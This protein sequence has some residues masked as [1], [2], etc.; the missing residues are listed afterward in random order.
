MVPLYYLSLTCRFIPYRRAGFAKSRS[1]HARGCTAGQK[2]CGKSGLGQQAAGPLGLRGAGPWA[3]AG[4]SNRRA[5]GLVLAKP[6]E[7]HT[8][9]VVILTPGLFIERNYAAVS[10]NNLCR[11]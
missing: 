2:N 3:A 4:S 9:K 7:G 10:F 8:K 5:A 11:K 1:V 6:T